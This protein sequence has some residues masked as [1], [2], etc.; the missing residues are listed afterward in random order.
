MNAVCDDSVGYSSEIW[1]ARETSPPS[2]WTPHCKYNDNDLQKEVKL[3]LNV[4]MWLMYICFC[5]WFFQVVTPSFQPNLEN[6]MSV[7]RDL[8]ERDIT[9]NTL[10]SNLDFGERFLRNHPIK[11]SSKLVV[12]GDYSCVQIGGNVRYVFTVTSENNQTY[13]NFSIFDGYFDKMSKLSIEANH[14]FNHSCQDEMKS[15]FTQA[16]EALAKESLTRLH[17][18]CNRF[19][20]H[21]PQNMWSMHNCGN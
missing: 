9:D 18:I 12:K 21:T 13:M 8:K 2:Q 16:Q 5:C 11:L 7:K 3:S 4:Y 6:I 19:S 20:V 10:I 14:F 15:C 17:I 1:P